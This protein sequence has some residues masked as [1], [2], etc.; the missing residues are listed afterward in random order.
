MRETERDGG[1]E[2]KIRESMVGGGKEKQ[3]NKE[4]KMKGLLLESSEKSERMQ[5]AK[6]G[7]EEWREGEGKH[8]GGRNLEIHQGW[9]S[10]W[11]RRRCDKRELLSNSLALNSSW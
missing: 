6:A 2:A 7:M 3:I 11:E 5:R 8:D 9:R 10:R 4:E 1:R